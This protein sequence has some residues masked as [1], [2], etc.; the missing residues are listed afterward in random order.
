MNADLGQ[1]DHP[2][3]HAAAG[4]ILGYALIIA[5]MTVALFVVPYLVFAAL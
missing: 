2:S 3:W 4:T 5:V 1:F